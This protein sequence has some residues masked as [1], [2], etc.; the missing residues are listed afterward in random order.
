MMAFFCSCSCWLD[1]QGICRGS[2]IFQNPLKVGMAGGSGVGDASSVI[3]GRQGS[4]AYGRAGREG[5]VEAKRK[6]INLRGDQPGVPEE[7]VRGQGKGHARRAQAA[8]REN[9]R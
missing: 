5:E 7:A 9:D 6:T 8:H 2:P 3:Q 4:D 1:R